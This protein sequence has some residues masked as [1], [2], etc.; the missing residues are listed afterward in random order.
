[1]TENGEKK[2]TDKILKKSVSGMPPFAYPL[3]AAR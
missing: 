3:F 2:V 1:M